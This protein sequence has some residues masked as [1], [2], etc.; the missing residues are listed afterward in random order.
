[1]TRERFIAVS[2][3]LMVAARTA[4]VAVTYRFSPSLSF[5][6]NPMVMFLGLGW[7]FLVAANVAAVLATVFCTIYWGRKPLQYEASPEVQDVWS[8]ASFA[9][10]HRIYS[11][12]DFIV[13]RLFSHPQGWKH[14]L[15]F[16]G[17]VLPPTFIVISASA[18]FSWYAM[19]YYHW[20]LFCQFY[21]ATWPVFPY[22]LTVPTVWISAALFYR[23]EY[24]CYRAAHRA[25]TSAVAR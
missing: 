25:P 16:L 11:P 10:F 13:R 2:S 15:H 12:T 4:D 24:E 7:P 17:V 14:T 1:M 22:A 5:E 3:L 9:C 20:E 8:F 23:N 21:K 18:V 6:G 19:Y